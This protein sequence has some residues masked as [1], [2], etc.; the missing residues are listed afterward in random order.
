MSGL[1]QSQSSIF[2]ESVIQLP[3]PPS[4][5]LIS[6]LPPSL[7]CPICHDLVCSPLECQECQTVFCSECLK[8]WLTKKDQC[9]FDCPKPFKVNKA[10]KLVR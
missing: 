7:L 8:L 6:P 5:L 10:H 1:L 9:P 4:N 2:N 3:P